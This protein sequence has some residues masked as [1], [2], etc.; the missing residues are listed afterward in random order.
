MKFIGLVWFGGVVSESLLASFQLPTVVYGSPQKK[1]G[2]R[3][4]STTLLQYRLVAIRA[5]DKTM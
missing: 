2:P 3:A 4:Y 1:R 5:G